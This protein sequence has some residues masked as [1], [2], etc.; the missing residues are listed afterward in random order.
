MRVPRPIDNYASFNKPGVLTDRGIVE[1]GPI[2][3]YGGHRPAL[4]RSD[5]DDAYGG[6]ENAWADVRVSIGRFGPW[7]SGIV[8][9]GVPDEVVYAARASRISGHW[10]K[11]LLKAIVSVNAEGYDVPGS[12]FANYEFTTDDAGVCELVASFPACITE[13]NHNAQAATE[14]EHA[15]EQAQ[16]Q[17]DQEDQGE[18]APEVNGWAAA[19]MIRLLVDER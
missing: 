11:G 19:Q 8:R 18:Q 4:G 10:V 9:P 2:F 16:G 12:G 7:L 6:I 17:G 14:D 13:E 15:Q 3:A 5:L 1:T